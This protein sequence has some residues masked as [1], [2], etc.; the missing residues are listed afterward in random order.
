MKF[1]FPAAAAFVLLLFVS[2]S[3]GIDPERLDSVTEFS[4]AGLAIADMENRQLVINSD[5][6]P[7]T[8]MF[9][10]II[11]SGDFYIACNSEGKSM[12]LD[13][14][15]RPVDSAETYLSD[16]TPYGLIWSSDDSENIRAT[17]LRSGNTVFDESGVE[18][19]QTKESGTSLLRR[20]GAHYISSVRCSGKRPVYDYMLVGADGRII[21]PWGKYKYIDNFS[22]GLARFTNSATHFRVRT[23]QFPSDAFEYAERYRQHRYG[24]I[25]ENGRIV[26]PERFEACDA[27]DE[28]GH[29]R[30]DEVQ[31]DS[32][33]NIIIDSSGDIVG[34]YRPNR[35]G[36]Y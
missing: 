7:V 1:S 17:D 24:Y 26:I 33:P 5:Y 34:R 11:S 20:C 28:N 6:E 35:G 18:L 36:L 21:A 27:F 3:K 29:A 12:V 13:S 2:C 22:Y 9:D 15:Y 23:G 30:A 32:E 25:D 4:D 19:L 8:P 14:S 10:Y 31:G 16:V